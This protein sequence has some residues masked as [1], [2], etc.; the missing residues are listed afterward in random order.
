[1]NVRII[2]NFKD[3]NTGEVRG[4]SGSVT[5]LD[6]SRED[7][8]YMFHVV[9]DSDSDEEDMELWDVEQYKVSI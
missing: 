6:W 1:M 5:S 8:S 2:K 3:D 9:Y 7:G 4:Y